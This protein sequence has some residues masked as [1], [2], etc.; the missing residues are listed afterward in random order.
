MPDKRAYRLKV[1]YLYGKHGSICGGYKREGRCALPGEVCL[2]VLKGTTVAE[3][4]GDVGA[5]VSRGHSRHLDRAEG[6]NEKVRQRGLYFDGE[7]DAG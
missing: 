6:L 4:R 7:G 5:E 1:Q 2:Y 3:R